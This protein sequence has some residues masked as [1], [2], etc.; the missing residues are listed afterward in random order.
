MRSPAGDIPRTDA[1]VSIIWDLGG[2]LLDTYPV[3]DRALA[4]VV[5]GGEPRDATLEEVA[6]LTRV[7]S[8]HAIATLSERY[9][10]PESELRDAYE[11]TKATW[12]VNPPPVMDGAREVIA[13]VTARGGL[14]LVATHRARESAEAL[15]ALVG[16]EVDD[17][18]SASDGFPRKPDPAMALELLRRHALDPSEVI[19]VGDRPGDVAAAE[20]AGGRGVLLTTAGLPLDA[21]DGMRRISSLRE[22]LDLVEQPSA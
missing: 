5:D 12:E 2:T 7:S 17:L 16:L 13:A 1:V 20:A 14:N 11:G 9:G 6:R 18:V 21:P 10:V 4:S 3:V 15:L 19:G 8:G 22:L